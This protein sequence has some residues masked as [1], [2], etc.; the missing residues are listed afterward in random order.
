MASTVPPVASTSS[1][2]TTR[3]PCAIASAATSRAFSPYSSRY[4]AVTVS[5]GSFPGRRAG[6]NPQPTWQAMAPPSRKPRAS[7]PRTRS[8]CRSAVHAASSSTDCRSAIGSSRSGVMSLK[9]MPGSGKSGT[10]RTRVFRSIA[11]T[12]S[13]AGEFTDVP[14]EEELGE[15][16]RRLRECLEVLDARA[17]P[18]RIPG[19]ERR[20][21]E[22]LKEARLP[23]RGRPE[24]PQVAWSDPEARQG[25]ARLRDVGVRLGVD[26]LPALD[27]RLEQAELLELSRAGRFD[28]PPLA[29]AL[30]I[31]AFFLL[32]ERGGPAPPPLLPRSRRELLA[33]HAQ[34]EKL[35]ALEAE[36]RLQPLEVVLAEQAVA[37]LRAL[38]RQQP[39]IPEVADLRDRD[40][41]E[42]RLQAPADGADR[43]QALGGWGGRS[44]Q[45]W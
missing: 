31:E 24:G 28:T 1:W 16:V 26:P 33:N 4:L 38:G 13:L 29:E 15:L 10:S 43:Q 12:R 19:A 37:A 22:R 11:V 35:V 27:A 41:R 5:G 36:D 44:H 21:D 40:V 39:L 30:E 42:L 2:M 32:A 34:R 23:V 6:T 7:A 45:G 17:A 14:R 18:L 9:P 3:A 25:L 8:G 20:P